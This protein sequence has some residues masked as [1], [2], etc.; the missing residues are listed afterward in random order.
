MRCPR[1]QYVRRAIDSTGAAECPQ[2][3]VPYAEGADLPLRITAG[4]H[5]RQMLREAAS[6][7]SLFVLLATNAIVLA[8]ALYLGMSLR[9][10]MLIYWMQSV[11]IGACHVARILTL[12]RFSVRG[13]SASWGPVEETPRTKRQMAA[14]FAG[15]FG[16][17][18]LVYLAFLLFPRRADVL[19]EPMAYVLCGLAFAVNHLFSLRRNVAKDAAG[20]PNIGTL[21]FMPYLRIVPMHVMIC[22]GLAF[23]GSAASIVFFALL[24]TA[25]DALMHVV[26][27]HFLRAD[28]EN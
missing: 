3:R 6:D 20:Q 8:V 21:M 11:V 5:S 9:S 23:G 4:E 15:H 10:L 1:C 25:A 27:H 12:E 19:A 22:T 24:K 16:F 7:S 18:H 14:F 26:E 28:R 2:C 17:F 13:A